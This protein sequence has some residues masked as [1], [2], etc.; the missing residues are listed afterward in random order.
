MGQRRGAERGHSG[1]FLRR[2]AVHLRRHDRHAESPQHPAAGD[3]EPQLWQLRSR[4]RSVVERRV[5]RALSTGGSRGSLRVRRRRRPRRGRMR[6]R[7]HR[8]HPRNRRQRLGLHSLQC[9][10]RRHRHFSDSYNNTSTAT[11]WAASQRRYQPLLGAFLHSGDSLERFLRQRSAST[12]FFGFT[13]P[14]GANGFCQ[15]S[16]ARQNQM[17][18]VA[19]GAI[20]N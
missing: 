2:H 13:T 8:C 6:R 20:R 14:Y 10:R 5:Q 18:T 3:H 9:G 7:R 17:V 1:R 16:T 11:Y 4:E 12:T 15:S 19:A